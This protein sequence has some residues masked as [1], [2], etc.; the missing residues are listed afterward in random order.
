MSEWTKLD[1]GIYALSATPDPS[2]L[3]ESD[4]AFNE[5]I[6]DK[7]QRSDM[8]AQE[9]VQLTKEKDVIDTEITQMEALKGE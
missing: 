9:M 5:L 8:Y 1:T 7:Q 4:E 3:I 6:A 2:K